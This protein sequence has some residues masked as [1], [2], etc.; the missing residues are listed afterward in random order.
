MVSSSVESIVIEFVAQQ[1]AI[2][3]DALDLFVAGLD[4]S[5]F[6]A[7]LSFGA[8]GIALL[9]APARQRVGER[10]SVLYE[11]YRSSTLAMSYLFQPDE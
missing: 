9:A 6:D 4:I 1:C 5:H 3:V 7:Q 11:P 10:K 8:G 2:R